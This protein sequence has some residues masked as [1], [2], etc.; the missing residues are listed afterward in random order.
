M[1]KFPAM[2]AAL[3]TNE[4]ELVAL[5]RTYLER[6]GHGKARVGAPK[7]LTTPTHD[8]ATVGTAIRL[9]DPSDQLAITEGIE[10]GLAVQEATGSPTWTS[11]CAGNMAA[12]KV[13]ESV[14]KVTVWADNDT[15]GLEAAQALADRLTAEGREVRVLIPARE[16]QIG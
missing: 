13:P 15:P 5:H 4:G 14:R 9:A 12:I 16:G 2:V 7:K 11:Y 10:T 6:D 3:I 8:G 1:G